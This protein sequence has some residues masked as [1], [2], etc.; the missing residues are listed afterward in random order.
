MTNEYLF[1]VGDY[2]TGD[3]EYIDEVKVIK[4]NNNELEE[5]LG[6]NIPHNAQSIEN[7]IGENYGINDDL[8]DWLQEGQTT[9]EIPGYLFK[10]GWENQ[11]E[12][13]FFKVYLPSTISE[14]DDFEFTDTDKELASYLGVDDELKV[15][16]IV[17]PQM[18][19]KE[20]LERSIDYLKVGEDSKDTLKQY[21][22]FLKEPHTI[23]G[24][25]KSEL[26]PN[27]E[28]YYKIVFTNGTNIHSSIL[29]PEFNV[30]ESLQENDDF[31]FTDA[32]K[33]LAM[34]L[35]IIELTI[36]DTIMPDM[37]IDVFKKGET[38]KKYEI[39]SLKSSPHK[40]T[41]IEVIG[42]DRVLMFGEIDNYYYTNDFLKPQY[43]VVLPDDLDE[44][45]EAWTKGRRGRGISVDYAKH[46]DYQ[47]QAKKKSFEKIKQD[48]E[49]YA[50]YLEK[51]KQTRE[52]LA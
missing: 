51:Q 10:H 46:L 52:K 17:I 32:D 1:W 48:P 6:Q 2:G 19:D 4:T 42:D 24:L 5:L 28:D 22:K 7:L 31:E 20:A 47:N 44:I 50:K 3:Q 34:G 18:W 38:L 41:N 11:W 8:I 9:Q 23:S 12:E 37:W 29:E 16:S 39:K 40:I 35:G 14:S 13:V 26:V 15:G 21:E 45:N 33:D 43:R 25:F 49:A 27:S 36:G 30:F